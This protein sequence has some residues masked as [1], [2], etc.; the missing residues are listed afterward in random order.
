MRSWK[1]AGRADRTAEEELWTR[2]KTAQDSFFQARSQ[3]LHAKD[4][5]L[6]EHASEKTRLL[7]EAERLVPVT[8]PRAARSAL[9]GIQERWERAGAVPRDSHERLEGGLRRGRGG[10]G[11]AGGPVT[12]GLTPRAYPPANS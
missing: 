6:R 11:P 7:A 10:G 2:F 12:P 5:E 3:V 9:R 1:E 4:S 8:D